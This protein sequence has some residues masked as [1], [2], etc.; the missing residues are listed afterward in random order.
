MVKMGKS[1]VKPLI[2]P[3][4]MLDISSGSEEGDEWGIGS[5]NDADVECL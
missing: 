2:S 1:E 4:S 5:E 3:S